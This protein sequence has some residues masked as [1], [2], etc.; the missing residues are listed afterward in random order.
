[1]RYFFSIIY[2]LSLQSLDSVVQKIVIL[3]F[4]VILMSDKAISSVTK[5]KGSCCK[6]LISDMCHM[7]SYALLKDIRLFSNSPR[8]G[9]ISCKYANCRNVRP[10][11]A[12]AGIAG[13]CRCFFGQRSEYLQRDHVACLQLWLAD[14]C[15]EPDILSSIAPA[16]SCIQS[17]RHDITIVPILSPAFATR[18]KLCKGK[19]PE[20]VMINNSWVLWAFFVWFWL[21]LCNTICFKR[22]QKTH[23]AFPWGWRYSLNDG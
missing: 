5:L 7:K 8:S 21:G 11:E 1:M 10:L 16:G 6:D 23:V 22:T 9:E 3:Q 18:S 2:L 19:S 12:T 14:S 4:S 20:N 15:W 13:Q 17:A